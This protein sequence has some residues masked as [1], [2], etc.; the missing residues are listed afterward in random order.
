MADSASCSGS[1]RFIAGT[2]KKLEAAREIS[3]FEHPGI[4]EN[5]VAYLGLFD[6]LNL[7][8]CSKYLNAV[9]ESD[10]TWKVLYE[11]R[12]E[13]Q[14]VGESSKGAQAPPDNKKGWKAAYIVRQKKKFNKI[15]FIL[16]EVQERI[17]NDC[18]SWQVFHGGIGQLKDLGITYDDVY[19]LFFSKRTN[20]ILTMLGLYYA[21]FIL[22]IPEEILK[23][24][25]AQRG[26]IDKKVC[27]RWTLRRTLSYGFNTPEETH[28]RV[29]SLGEVVD[30]EM[31]FLHLMRMSNETQR[32]DDPT[33][34]RMRFSIP[35]QSEAE[36]E[37]EFAC[38]CLNE[39]E[40][41]EDCFISQEAA[42]A[43]EECVEAQAEEECVKKKVDHTGEEAS[44]SSA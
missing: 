17:Q 19:S 6:V 10:S 43:G 41:E 15:Y 11:R 9:S 3:L 23:K 28:F 34:A 25:L 21:Y 7:G 1:R 30:K 5:V 20:V 37:I 12:W 31:S 40:E 42:Q 2:S 26:V 33:I 27:A 8:C 36:A 29:R 18:L 24:A 16:A 44:S 38:D 32:R 4:V 13:P 39:E 35:E 22:R 14:A